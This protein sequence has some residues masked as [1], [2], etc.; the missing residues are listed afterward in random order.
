MTAYQRTVSGPD[1]WRLI[2]PAGWITLST[3]HARRE[4]DIK[5]LLDRQFRR[6][7]R[8]ELIQVRIEA[9]RRLRTQI[10]S[11]AEHG[12]TQIHG[13]ADPVKGLPVS[14]TLLVAQL[15]T[16]DGSTLGPQLATLLGASEGVTE[17]S[18][19]E[20]AGR[21]ALRRVRR[22]EEPAD[23]ETDGSPLIWHTHVD[24]LVQADLDR[25][26]VLS[27]VTSTD[28]LADPLVA[29][30][31]TIAGTLHVADEDGAGALAWEPSTRVP[32]AA[33]SAP[34]DTVADGELADSLTSEETSA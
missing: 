1:A 22:L 31:D 3:D 24:Y 28:P 29:L 18:A 8:D 17:N 11:A 13:L 12:V 21:T 33:T 30:F 23:P 4:A 26:L 5:R 15:F 10:S 2:L 25:V 14:A 32:D 19:T 27:F 20:L 16:G 6:T 9:D 7:A 34:E